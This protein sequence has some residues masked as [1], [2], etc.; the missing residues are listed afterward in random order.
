MSKDKRTYTVGYGKPPE[1]TRFKPGQSGNPAGRQKG[2]RNLAGLIQEELGRTI[3]VT[4]DGRRQKQPKG[5][6]LVRLQVDKALKGDTKAFQAV[7]SLE[8]AGQAAGSQA[9]EPAA[10]RDSADEIAAERHEE[11]VRAFLAQFKG[12]K[13]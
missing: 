3:P 2:S 10:A 8:K 7:V 11:I 5:R 13:A 4:V 12:E 6:L 9:P 1:A